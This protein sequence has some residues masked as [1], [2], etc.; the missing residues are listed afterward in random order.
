[1]KIILIS[2]VLV[3]L[4]Q[5]CNAQFGSQMWPMG[6]M[7]NRGQFNRRG[8]Q[9][10]DGYPYNGENNGRYNMGPGYGPLLGINL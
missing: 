2:A 1:M 7:T 5:L 3:L 10:Y 9:D 8:N 4:F 6:M